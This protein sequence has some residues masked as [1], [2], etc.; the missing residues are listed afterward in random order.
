MYWIPA[1]RQCVRN[2]LKHCVVYNK[3]C[4][5]HFRAPDPPPLPKHRVQVTEPFTVTG[6][7]FTGPLYVRAL[8]RENKV[9]ICLFTCANTHAVHLEAVNDLSEGTFLQAFH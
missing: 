2:I 8:K 9:Y 7:D 5:S 4:R 6:A 1:A 3:L